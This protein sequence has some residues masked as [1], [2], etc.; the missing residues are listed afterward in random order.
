M[1]LEGLQPNSF[2]IPSVVREKKIKPRKAAKP[3]ASTDTDKTSYQNSNT[4]VAKWKNTE[5]NNSKF[6]NKNKTAL[7][8]P[9]T[10]IKPADQPTQSKKIIFDESYIGNNSTKKNNAKVQP[11]IDLFQAPQN[12]KVIFDEDYIL[13][14][15]NSSG[16][17]NNPM[18]T[19]N[20]EWYN[21]L[22]KP[23]VVWYQQGRKDLPDPK[24]QPSAEE[25]RKCEEEGKKYLEE[26][27]V[28]FQRGTHYL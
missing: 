11:P 22:I 8:P 26:D 4:N 10:T 28:N 9:I 14:S 2:E 17:E 6:Q 21:L 27:T 23:D 3:K 1:G 20:Q 16:L 15:S 18:E 24:E 19:D 7:K 13:K 25:V 5:G 12:K